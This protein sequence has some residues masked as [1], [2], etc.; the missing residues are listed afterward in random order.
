MTLIKG[1]GV[2]LGGVK[3]RSHYQMVLSLRRHTSPYRWSRQYPVTDA[4]EVSKLRLA[5]TSDIKC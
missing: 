2:L 3:S 5:Y 4:A 1:G